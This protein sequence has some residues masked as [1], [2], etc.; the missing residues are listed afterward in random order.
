MDS[1]LKAVQSALDETK[2]Q[3]KTAIA[4][5]QVSAEL[6]KIATEAIDLH[7]DYLK[8]FNSLPAAEYRT[9]QQVQQARHVLKRLEDTGAQLDLVSAAI[10]VGGVVALAINKASR[11]IQSMLE[12]KIK[13]N[14]KKERELLKENKNKDKKDKEEKKKD[15]D[16]KDKE[17]KNK[18]AKSIELTK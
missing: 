16:K 11:S 5:K 17:E 8:I 14:E 12:K 6:S 7:N 15:K 1:E 4:I 18:K 3:L 10:T 2:K 13:E 9:E